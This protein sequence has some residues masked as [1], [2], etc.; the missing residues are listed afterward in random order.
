MPSAVEKIPTLMLDVDTGDDLAALKA[1]LAE[2]RGQAPATREALRGLERLRAR[3]SRPE[4]AARGLQPP[5]VG[6]QPSRTGAFEHTR[7]A[8]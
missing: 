1:A 7:P 3:P 8:A 6:L 5:S 4:R 2:R